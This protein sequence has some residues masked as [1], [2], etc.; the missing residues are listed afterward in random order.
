MDE[1]IGIT[2][3]PVQDGRGKMRNI[4][5]FVLMAAMTLSTAIARGD[6][7]MWPLNHLPKQTLKEKYGFEPDEAWIKHVQ[8]ASVRVG[9]GGSASFVS[10]DGLLMTNHHVAADVIAD[11]SDEKHDYDRD[12]FYAPTRDKELKCP[13][14]ELNV[15]MEIE[16]VTDKVNAGVTDKMSPAEAQAARKKAKAEIEKAAKERTGMQPE[17]VELYQGARYDLYLYKRYTDVRLVFAPESEIAFFGG[18]PE[19]F[20]YPR[21]NLD[22]SFL[23]AYEDGKPA[24]TPDYL[25]WSATGPKDGELTLISGH[26][27]RTQ[28][29]YTADHLRFLRDAYIPLLL[30]GYNQREVALMLFSSRSAEKRR[31]AKEDLYGIQNGRKAYCGILEGLLD[32]GLMRRKEAEDTALQEFIKA[33]A[34]RQ[35]KYGGA[36]EKLSHALAETRSYYPE[37]FLMENRRAGLCRLFGIASRLVRA[38]EERAKPDGERLEEYRDANLPSLEDGLFSTAPIYP[39]FERFKMEDSLIRLGRALGGEH[40]YVQASYGGKSAAAKAAELISGTK[41]AD[42]AFRKKLYQGGSAAIAEC[43]D[44]MIR[45]AVQLDPAARKVRKKYEDEFESVEKEVYAKLAKA[46]FEKYGE[47]VYPD[48]TFT[49]RLAIGTVKGYQEP[50][51]AVPSMTNYRGLYELAAQHEYQDPYH[52]PKRWLDRKDKLDLGVPFNFVSTNDIIGGNSGSPIFNRKAELIGIVFDGNIHGLIWD[53]QFSDELGRAVGVH[54]QGIIEALRKVYDA[55]ALV[56]EL[57]GKS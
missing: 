2:Q 28:R 50:G 10:P 30:N 46:R 11:L 44:P 57:L 53:F 1:P 26:P 48:A 6:E 5:T 36:S 21:F 51:R 17:I 45:Y 55:G 38:A 25:K 22:I 32:D 20:E 27:G 7:G 47:S 37:Y 13:H 33:D 9:A 4:P 19:N 12:G 14:L 35:E 42:V 34:S 23:R 31:I 18:D 56:D 16:P 3:K 8:R 40:P 15:L 49:L 29:L 39:E 43:Q 52:L 41:L 54:S 24:K